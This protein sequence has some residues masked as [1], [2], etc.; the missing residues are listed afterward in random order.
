MTNRERLLAIMAGNSPDRIPWIPRLQLWYEAH[1]RQSILP[2]RFEGWALRDI[3]RALGL[4][5]PAREGNI[6]RTELH[7][8][9]VRSRERGYD[10]VTE[11]ITP[12]GTVSTVVRRSAELDRAAIQ[13]L[14]VEKMIKG[15]DDYPI[16][17]YII[18][19]TE[20]IPT[21]N[22]YLAYEA[23]IGE[24]G[25]PMVQIVADPI[26]QILRGYIG[27]D[28]AYYHLNDYPDLVSHLLGVLTE[29]AAEIQQVVLDS[30][31]RLILHGHHFHS[32]MT[33]PYLF[34]KYMLPYFRPFAERLHERDKLLVCHADADTTG[35]LDLIVEAGFDMA[36]CFVT[37]PMV[38]MTLERARAVLGT[39]VIIWGG[40]P[41]VILDDSVSSEAF[42]AYMHNLFR[43]ITPGDAFILG[44]A[45][46]VMPESKLERVERVT[47]MVEAYGVYPI[48]PRSTVA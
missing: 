12:V 2:K 40:I 13:G 34:E 43:A 22:E 26:F 42:E 19:H 36:E 31:A 38:S 6:M 35:L 48:S 27:F 29:Q 10:T 15:S 8:V 28:N 44:V 14:E 45:D 1:K 41:S 33:P 46:N 11:Y 16:V 20:I 32:Q 17:E 23:E 4:G 24:D 47:E 7:G 18:Q 30:P 3:E 37:A 5:T 9:E 25:V 21:Y 39:Q